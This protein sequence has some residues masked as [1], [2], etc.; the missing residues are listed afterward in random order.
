[1]AKKKKKNHRKTCSTSLIIREMHI[2]TTLGYELTPVRMAITKNSTNS[3]C[4]RGCGGKGPSYT[5]GRNI[6]WCNHSGEQCGCSLKK[7]KSGGKI[8]KY[9]MVAIATVHSSCHASQC[10]WRG[11]LIE[12]NRKWRNRHITFITIVTT[13]R[14]YWILTIGQVLAY[15]RHTP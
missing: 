1:M 9:R 5:V 3:K 8:N 4:W 7:K 14:I 2:E 11:S 12:E 10:T 15:A 13:A 6:N